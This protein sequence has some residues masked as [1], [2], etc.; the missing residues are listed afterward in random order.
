VSEFDRNRHLVNAKRLQRVGEL[1]AAL[2]SFV[3]QYVEACEAGDEF[4]RANYLDEVAR[5]LLLQH[6]GQLD[7]TQLDRL[8]E[9]AVTSLADTAQGRDQVRAAF[10][11]DRQLAVLKRFAPSENEEEPSP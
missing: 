8:M 2:R 4:M 9:Q 11:L 3:S 7:A 10:E 1:E 5:T 6:G